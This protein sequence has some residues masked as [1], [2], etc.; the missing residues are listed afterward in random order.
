MRVL[1]ETIAG[2]ITDLFLPE[3]AKAVAD[4]VIQAMRL[5]GLDLVALGVSREQL[6]ER[7]RNTMS[8]SVSSGSVHEQTVQP[9]RARQVARKRLDERIR[10]AS[11]QLLNE[12]QITVIGR[13]LPMLFPQTGATNNI[14]AAIILLNMQVQEFLGLGP[15]ERDIATT[16]Q[17]VKAHDEIDVVIDAVAVKVREK[18]GG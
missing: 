11:K 9:Q 4:D 14:T 3:D 13:D 17:L 6:E 8:E 2:F 7:I 12:L 5:R 1:Q 10:S 15:S 16:E 18:K